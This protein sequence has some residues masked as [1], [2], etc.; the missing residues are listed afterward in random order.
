MTSLTAST[1]PR[2]LLRLK[3]RPSPRPRATVAPRLLPNTSLPRTH[4]PQS[5]TKMRMIRK[6]V[7]TPN[8][9]RPHPSTTMPTTMPMIRKEVR[10][11]TT[12]HP[13]SSTTM[14]PSRKG[15]RAPI[16]L[17]VTRSDKPLLS[18]PHT[19]SN[20]T[21]WNSPTNTPSSLPRT[22]I[23]SRRRNT[24]T[25]LHAS[26]LNLAPDRFPCTTTALSRQ[27]TPCKLMPWP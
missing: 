23:S 22:H 3:R 10:H 13:Q 14:P 8:T 17:L 20:N 16:S 4:R 12:H 18:S 5:T 7:R 15:V 6:E 11:H 27:R 25:Q 2:S 24:A 1:S 21:Q 9:R 26:S 19:N